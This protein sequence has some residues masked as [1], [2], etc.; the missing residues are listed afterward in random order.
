MDVRQRSS[1]GLRIDWKGMLRSRD[2]LIVNEP[3]SPILMLVIEQLH[4]TF[5]R[6]MKKQN[7][8]QSNLM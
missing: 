6:L 5:E 3:S 2:L 8:L 7:G 1:Y 4:K